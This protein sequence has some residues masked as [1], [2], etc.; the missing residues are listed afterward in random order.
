MSGE[1]PVRATPEP[2]RLL[3]AKAAGADRA[4]ADR[5][6]CIL[7]TL[8]G[9]TSRRLAEAFGGR[10]DAVGLWRSQFM[11]G[12]VEALETRPPPGPEPVKTHAA[13]RV[14]EPFL[15]APATNRINW[16]P[17]R[18]ADE[19]AAQEGVTISKSQ[20]STALRKKGAFAIADPATR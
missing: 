18:L 7:V 15:S 5:A 9:R 12:G 3:E 2:V 13:L 19:I 8:R 11:N 4:E 20:L 14:A 10:E 6:R 17:A 16:T 1:S